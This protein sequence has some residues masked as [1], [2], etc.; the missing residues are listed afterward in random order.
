MADVHGKNS[1]D[2]VHDLDED[3]VVPNSIPPHTHVVGRKS[4]TSLARILKFLDLFEVTH[5]STLHRAIELLVRAVKLFGRGNLPS[6]L[7]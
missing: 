1:Q 5:H 4:F 7:H 3:A 2:I 6:R